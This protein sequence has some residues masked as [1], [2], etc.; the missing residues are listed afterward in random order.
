MNVDPLG[1]RLGPLR[2]SRHGFAAA[3]TPHGIDAIDHVHRV[4][5]LAVGRHVRTGEALATVREAASRLADLVESLGGRGHGLN[6]VL[7]GF[8]T[9]HH[10]LELPPARPK[11]LG[12][13][14]ERELK[15]LEPDLSEP[16]IG[17]SYEPTYRGPRSLPPAVVA[18]AVPQSTVTI[19]AATLEERGIGLEHVTVV[20]Q[21]MQRLYLVFAD[22]HDPALLA[23]VTPEVAVIA[24]FIEGRVR[25]CWESVVRPAPGGAIDLEVLGARL[26]SGRHFI[27]QTSRGQTP[28]KVLLAA[29]PEEQGI[30]AQLVSDTLHIQSEPLGPPQASP[31]A[32]LALGASLDAAGAGGLNLLPPWLKPSV[33]ADPRLRTIAAAVCALAVTVTGWTA[34]L[35]IQR[36]ARASESSSDLETLAAIEAQL[37]TI[38]PILLARREHAA[39]LEILN[40]LAGERSVPPSWL[41]AVA[42]ATPPA[43]QLDTLVIERQEEGWQ[44]RLSGTAVGVHVASAMQAVDRMFRELRHL[45]P[46][47]TIGLLHLSDASRDTA[48]DAAVEF[49][50]SVSAAAPAIPPGH[51]PQH[52]GDQTREP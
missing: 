29:E 22:Q 16:L 15:R 31:G 13:V 35:G 27:Q 30:V 33:G 37:Q 26:A 17:F 4:H 42:Q 40:R 36:A 25:L 34:W 14:V 10:V 12:P 44:M 23:L 19:I 48:P 24:A 28:L 6:L 18:A 38:E 20:P 32:L 41:G 2:G 49:A 46:E 50:I 7:S 11:L 52:G 9:R 45:L 51:K 47:A 3:L 5:G 21:A 43:V 39:R 8:D 1:K